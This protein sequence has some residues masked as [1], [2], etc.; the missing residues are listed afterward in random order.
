MRIF[1]RCISRREYA[2]NRKIL[3]Q[4]LALAVGI[5]LVLTFVFLTKQFQ[6]FQVVKPPT[7]EVYT[8]INYILVSDQNTK[9]VRAVVDRNTYPTDIL[10]TLSEVMSVDQLGLYPG[11]SM[12]FQY[13]DELYALD[14][15][16]HQKT[17]SREDQ[18]HYMCEI[19]VNYEPSEQKVRMS[20]NSKEFRTVIRLPN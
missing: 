3:M 16:D 14:S 11:M 2:M 6:A 12:V 1:I 13:F 10:K 5:V 7:M 8:P 4:L 15:W 20:I 19:E 9:L 18:Q 17:I